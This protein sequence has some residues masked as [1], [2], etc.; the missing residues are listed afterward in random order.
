MYVCTRLANHRTEGG[1]CGNDPVPLL[2]AISLRFNGSPQLCLTIRES[3]IAISFNWVVIRM[4]QVGSL[5]REPTLY[6]RPH[7]PTCVL[8][9]DVYVMAFVD[10]VAGS[11]RHAMEQCDYE[12]HCLY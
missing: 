6:A 8:F 10:A 9:T 7:V 12:S 1:P 3:F 5:L 11:L 4:M 2:R